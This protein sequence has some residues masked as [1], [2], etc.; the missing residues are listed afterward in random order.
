MEKRNETK[1]D[2]RRGE[3]EIKKNKVVKWRKGVKEQ[4]ESDSDKSSD[5]NLSR[6]RES[7]PLANTPDTGGKWSSS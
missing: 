4:E 6:Q 5:H 1:G 3:R 2:E 7:D